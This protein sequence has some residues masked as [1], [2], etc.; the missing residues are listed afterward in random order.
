MARPG[1]RRRRRWAAGLAGLAH[2]EQPVDGEGLEA[3]GLAVLVDVHELGQVV[4]V[5]D[6][7]G[8]EDLA[9]RPGPGVEQVALGPDGGGQR[10]DQL[11]AD[12]VER[13]VGHLGEELG[14][15]VVEQPGA[16]GEHGDGRVR[17][18]RADRLGPGAGH[19]GEDDPQLLGGVAEQPL[20]GHHPAVL[21]REHGAG[22]Q[23]V[24]ADL[25]VGQPLGV[26]VLGGQLGLDLVV[27][28]DAALGGVD[29]E[30]AAGLQP[31]LA[32]DALGVDVEHAHL[33]G[34]HHQAVVGDPVAGRAQ[35][36]AVEHGADH[37]AVGEGHRG[38]AVPGLHQRGVVAVEGP[39][40]RVHGGVV[41]PR[42]GD[43]HEHGVGQGPPAEVQQLEHLV[44]AGRVA[45]P[46]RA[47][48]VDP[49]EVARDERGREQ[50][51]AGPHPVAVAGQRVDL[52]VVGHVPVRV[53]QRPAGEGVGGEA[54][55]HQGQA[56]LERRSRRSG[57]NW[58]SCSEVSMPL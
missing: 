28:D 36:V 11:L 10:G 35:A 34:Q 48:R 40:G 12:G 52:P 2:R 21:G 17:A 30:H 23:V 49:V 43:H 16:V 5:D 15:V 14:E 18:H 31:A 7:Q 26:G 57:K 19:G 22:R 56:G 32:H 51:L 44:E 25:V 39:P 38:R 42:L 27:V 55:V 29:Q 50:R 13:R 6:R 20:V 3:R 45:R 1:P 9:A 41:L 33:A 53:G 58:R 24:E 54:R 8:Q 47:D 37:R 46:G 4:A